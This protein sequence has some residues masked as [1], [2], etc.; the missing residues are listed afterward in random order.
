MP[1][2]YDGTYEVEVAYTVT[3]SSVTIPHRH[4]FDVAL[5]T[6]PTPGQAADTILTAGKDGTSTDLEAYL[7]AYWGTVADL[8]GSGTSQPIFTLWQYAPEP[9][10]DKQFICQWALSVPVEYSPNPSVAA[11]QT[12]YTFRSALGGVMR[13][14]FMEDVVNAQN[15]VLSTSAAGAEQ[16]LIQF[17]LNDNSAILAR[18][19][20]YIVGGIRV[21][22]GY[23]EKLT[24]LRYRPF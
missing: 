13:L 18:D 15:Y 21:N 3:V 14:Q 2:N 16:A 12:T 4:T 5:D 10:K 9:S 6:I 1:V 19:N 22:Y 7:I 11:H 23:N 20:G 8:M 17:V 24:R